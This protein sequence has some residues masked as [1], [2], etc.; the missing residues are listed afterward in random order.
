MQDDGDGCRVLGVIALFLSDLVKA[1]VQKNLNIKKYSS[2]DCVDMKHL[3][4]SYRNTTQ[5]NNMAL[6]L[7]VVFVNFYSPPSM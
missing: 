6:Y 7:S 3:I 2:L 5:D 1:T 4:D